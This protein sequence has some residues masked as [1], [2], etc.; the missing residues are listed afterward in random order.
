MISPVRVAN[1]R[2]N[3]RNF[4][5]KA[6]WEGVAPLRSQHKATASFRAENAS[7]RTV[8]NRHK[9]SD[10]SVYTVWVA[11]FGGQIPEK[12]LSRDLTAI[13]PRPFLERQT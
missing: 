7:F 3:R 5:F 12:S 6:I 9:I 8:K 13:A 2:R 1:K 10:L 11:D 4:D